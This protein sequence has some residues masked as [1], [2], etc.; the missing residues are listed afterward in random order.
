MY[1]K[2]FLLMFLSLIMII[3]SGC[4]QNGPDLVP[5]RRSGSQGREGFCRTE[6]GILTVRVRNQGNEDVLT[7]FTTTVVFSPGGPVSATTPPMPTGSHSDVQ[8]EIPVGCFD[9][10]CNFTI[11]VDAKNE[12]KETIENNNTADGKCIG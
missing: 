10:D 1:Y 5:E 11:T 7:Q 2:M 3:L 4:N 6:D 12:V 9:P 8:F